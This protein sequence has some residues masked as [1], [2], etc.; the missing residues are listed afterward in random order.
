MVENARVRRVVAYMRLQP[1]RVLYGVPIEVIVE[2]GEHPDAVFVPITETFGYVPESAARIPSTIGILRC[3]R[4]V[5]A[6]IGPIGGQDP[7]M[8]R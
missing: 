7:G 5:E 1:A 4:T 8:I 2:V 3:S 6:E